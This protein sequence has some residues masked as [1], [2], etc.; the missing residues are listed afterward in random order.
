LLPR[1]VGTGAVRG[2][3]RGRRTLEPFPTS[4]REGLIHVRLIGT[5][6]IDAPLQACPGEWESIKRKE[7][8][9]VKG[10]NRCGYR[11]GPGCVC[12]LGNEPGDDVDSLRFR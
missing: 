7:Y 3:E 1:H 8:Q 9:S 12:G 6:V 2:R 4:G 5:A 11:N 10:G